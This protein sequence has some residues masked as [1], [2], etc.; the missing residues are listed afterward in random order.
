L[1]SQ[2]GNLDL[3]EAEKVEGEDDKEGRQKDVHPADWP[4]AG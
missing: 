3:E 4:P 2:L 1:S